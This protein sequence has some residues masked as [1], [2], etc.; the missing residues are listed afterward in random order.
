MPTLTSTFLVELSSTLRA[1][2]ISVPQLNEFLRTKLDR[3]F[4]DLTSRYIPL[5]ESIA[6]IV[7]KAHEQGW[8]ADLV[9]E[10]S[11]DRPKNTALRKLQESLPA[12]DPATTPVTGRSQIDRPSLLCGR[13]SQWQ[14]VCQCAPTRVHQTLLVPGGR[15]QEPLH[16]RERVQVWLTPDPSRTMLTVHWKTPPTSLDEMVDALAVALGTGIDGVANVLRDKLAFKN[17]VVLHP[18]ISDGFARQHFVDYHIK[19]LPDVLVHRTAG[20]LKCLQPIE[21]PIRERSGGVLRR[22]LALGG[23]PDERNSA[24]GLVNE[25]KRLQHE[26]L[27]IID[28]DELVNL[29]TREIE[30]F[31]EGSEFPVEH[32]RILLTQLLGGPQ[33][34]GY[35]FKTIDEYWRNMGGT[36]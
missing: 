15:G 33:V 6:E 17:L 29:E 21:W 12:L 23:Q 16:F 20:V 11:E 2:Y 5:S 32:Q 36:Q 3:R 8:L 22:W 25:L 26:R 14:E 13:A 28:V 24:L 9:R 34:P 18:C 7:R 19:W 4:D 30:Q 31:L 35:I 27:R 1:S 10:A